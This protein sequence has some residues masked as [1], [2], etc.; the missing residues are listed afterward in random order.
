MA[1]GASASVLAGVPIRVSGWRRPRCRPVPPADIET[2]PWRTTLCGTAS[3]CVPCRDVGACSAWLR[4]CRGSFRGF[5]GARTSWACFSLR[6]SSSSVTY[7]SSPQHRRT[8][9]R[10][11]AAS[12]SPMCLSNFTPVPPTGQHDIRLTSGREDGRDGRDQSV[13][14]G[15]D[16]FA[17]GGRGLDDLTHM[18]CTLSMPRRASR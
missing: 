6:S 8:A 18:Y 4:R 1:T 11:I 15:S 12:C 3:H 9:Y 13:T 2:S 16:Q 14:G 10:S 7:R 17:S 5:C